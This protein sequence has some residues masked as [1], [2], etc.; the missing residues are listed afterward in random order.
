MIKHIVQKWLKPV[1]LVCMICSVAA[2]TPSARMRT[3]QRLADMNPLK[4][5][6]V[7]VQTPSVVLALVPT[8]KTERDERIFNAELR[9]AKVYFAERLASELKQMEDPLRVKRSGACASGLVM[10]TTITEFNPGG[11]FTSMVTMG[12]AAD[13]RIE[14]AETGQQLALFSLRHGKAV[15]TVSSVVAMA[16]PIPITDGVS[17][18]P[19]LLD[20]LV[21]KA[22][23]AIEASFEKEKSRVGKL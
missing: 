17:D 12:F 19:S 8:F 9:M 2:C 1:A 18:M 15:N 22:L 13:L 23:E 14:K 3:E 10:R 7:R 4:I 11:R 16:S 21:E 5:E 20:S 6:C